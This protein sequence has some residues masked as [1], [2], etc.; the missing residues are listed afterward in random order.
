MLLC[1]ETLNDR[2]LRLSTPDL[3][4]NYLMRQAPDDSARKQI[5]DLWNDMLEQMGRRDINRFLRHLWVSKYGDLKKVDLFTA[6]KTRIENDHA[7]VLDFAKTCALEC[8]RYMEIL[9][10]EE[11]VFGE[12]VARNID[13]L[14][15]RLDFQASFPLLLSS[16]GLFKTEDFGKITRWILVFVARYS[17]IGH[18]DPSGLENVLFSLA[19]EIRSRMAVDDKQKTAATSSCLGYIKETLAGNSPTDEDTARSAAKLIVRPDDAAYI[20]TRLANFIQSPTKEIKVHETNV[21]HIFPKKPK[22]DEWGGQPN[23]EKLEPYLWHLG[24]L[25]IYGKRLNH[26]SANSEFEAK[27]ADYG[28]KTEVVMTKAIANDFTAWDVESIEKRAER[29]AADAVVVWNFNN[30]SRV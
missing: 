17:L 11:E 20:L 1:F 25:T 15:R 8:A 12:E 7:D 19:R 29:L 3:F 23:Q 21:E 5:R 14:V 16:H 2:G 27:R 10:V 9:N 13:S 6:L 18:L 22:E 4:L 26:S 30:P 24:N 28:T